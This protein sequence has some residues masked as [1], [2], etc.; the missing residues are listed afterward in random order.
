MYHCIKYA[1]NLQHVQKI[2]KHMGCCDVLLIK[3]VIIATLT[4]I[5]VHAHDGTIDME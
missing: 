3:D 2:A 4:I 5:L 1:I